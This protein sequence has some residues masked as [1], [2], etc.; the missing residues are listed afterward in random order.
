MKGEV[1]NGRDRFSEERKFNGRETA[2][3][4]PNMS[5]YHSDG[6]GRDFFISADSVM[7]EGKHEKSINELFPN[8]FEMRAF[9]PAKGVPRDT[10]KECVQWADDSFADK[11][12]LREATIPSAYRGHRPR[13]R[14][15]I[16]ESYVHAAAHGFGE[17]SGESTKEEKSASAESA[18]PPAASSP[19]KWNRFETTTAASFRMEGGAAAISGSVPDPTASQRTTSQPPKGDHLAFV[20]PIPGY[21]G[22]RPRLPKNVREKMSATPDGTSADSESS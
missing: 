9:R 22:H 6:S 14:D 7:T 10:A 1:E 3:A 2:L 11:R 5:H 13:V 4:V 15:V 19:V 18:P 8:P 17:G 12:P 21:M 20:D 16:G